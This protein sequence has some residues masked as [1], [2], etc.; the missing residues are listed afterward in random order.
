[1]NYSEKLKNPQWQKMRLKV[2]ERDEWSCQLCGNNEVTLN[3]HH[4]YYE[5]DKEPWDYPLNCFITLCEECHTS[6][7]E[8][9]ARIEQQ[10]LEILRKRRMFSDQLVALAWAL[11]QTSFNLNC[12]INMNALSFGLQNDDVLKYIM[13]AYKQQL[14]ELLGERRKEKECQKI[15]I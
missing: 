12:N 11:D 3:V 15:D 1:M 7:L 14:H 10:L 13:D 4:F 2:F 5:K 8:N 9:R 6:E